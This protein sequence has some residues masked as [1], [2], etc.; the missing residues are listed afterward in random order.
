MVALAKKKQGQ[1]QTETQL[2]NQRLSFSGAYLAVQYLF[3]TIQISPE[4]ITEQTVA[5]LISLIQSSKFDKKK[6]SFFLHKEA[7]CALTLISENITHPLAGF[8]IFELQN[9]LIKGK[10]NKRRAI[11]EALGTLPIK[12][13]GPDIQKT[14]GVTPFEISYASLLNH[15]GNL[16][17]DSMKWQG[18]TLTFRINN[19]QTACIKF[20]KSKKNTKDLISEANWFLFL[21]ENPPCLKSK[22][23]IPDPVIINSNSLLRLTNLPDFI[24]KNIDLWNGYLAIAYITENEY[25]NYPNE[26]VLFKN[27]KKSLIE[28]F[29]R[30]AWLLGKLTSQGIIHTAL[31][32]LFHNR[33]QQSRREDQGAYLWEHG[34]RLDQWLESTQY[35]NFAISGLRDFEHLISIK[36]TK[37]LHHFIGEHILGFVLVA[38]SFFR[39]KA[40]EKKGFDKQGHP[41]DIRYLFDKPLFSILIKDIVMLY[42]QGV[43][44][45]VLKGIERFLNDNLIENLIE[46]MGIDQHM[47][48][49]LRSQ[50]QLNMSDSEF[51][52]FLISRG[53]VA[54]MLRNVKKGEHDIILDTGPHLGG[55]NQGISVPELLDFLFCLSS[56]CIS[57]RYIMENGLKA[58]LN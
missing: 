4:L 37:R 48:E 57:D 15:F 28:V 51:D 7:A 22:F 47:D 30:N 31:I 13:S 42:Y 11:S 27:Q 6:Q 3:L 44:G 46:K 52:K 19:S 32:P 9:L 43:T 10:G 5:A 18:R 20:A 14:H 33:V 58:S 50:D 23:K 39:N 25:F 29:K 26:P 21:K 2:L 40:P 1:I 45:V 35:P 38:G 54:S 41:L 56:L 12:I 36:T 53:Y 55:F 24:V 34:G 8:C 16:N 49:T 17:L